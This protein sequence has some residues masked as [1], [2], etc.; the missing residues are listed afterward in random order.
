MKHIF[1]LLEKLFVEYGRTAM[2]ESVD[3]I[4][5]A[6]GF[7]E[8]FGHDNKILRAFRGKPLIAH[9]LQLLCSLPSLDAIHLVHAS[10]EVRD[11]ACE[12]GERVHL[13]RNVRPERGICESVR[14]GV[15]A[16]AA[17]Y[18]LFVPCD[19]PLLD[20]ATISLVLLR[21][22]PGGI[23]VPYYAGNPG[24]PA[25]FSSFFRQELLDIPD[26]DSPRSIKQKYADRVE[27]V[28]ISDPWPL[29][30]IDTEDDFR[31]FEQKR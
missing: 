28:E 20:V 4:L 23:V 9:A 2:T 3:A 6:S 16:S 29:R 26:G 31:L 13:V 17:A 12:W 5:L 30:D 15:A 18:Y 27:A 8:R 11:V 25:L 14:L 21:R 24:N 1:F 19:Q 22:R 10:E 7:S